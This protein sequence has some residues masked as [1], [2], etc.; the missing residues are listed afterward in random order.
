MRSSRVKRVNTFRVMWADKDLRSSH[1]SLVRSF[2]IFEEQ[3]FF[4]LESMYVERSEWLQQLG[5]ERG[6]GLRV[7]QKSS[8]FES[9]RERVDKDRQD[10][11]HV[12]V[13]KD[14]AIFPLNSRGSWRDHFSTQN[15]SNFVS[16]RSFLTLTWSC[17][18]QW[19]QDTLQT[20][21]QR[22]PST[23]SKG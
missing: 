16:F 18:S 14:V 17:T 21:R 19:L 20:G 3:H 15:F 9:H 7:K 11:V 13:Q 4:I 10:S 23:E 5:G 12:T 22:H 2:E 6:Q 1:F 8:H